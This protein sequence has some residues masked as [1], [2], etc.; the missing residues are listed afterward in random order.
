[1]KLCG[2][3]NYKEIVASIARY[4]YISAGD[5]VNYIMAD[6]GQPHIGDSQLYTRFWGKKIWFEVP[7]TF[8]EL[9][10]DWREKF[11][12]KG[13]KYG[14]WNYNE[15]KILTPE[16]YPNTESFEW[17]AQNAIWGT[18]GLNGDEQ[19]KYIMLGDCSEQHLIKIKELCEIRGKIDFI[20]K[21]EYWLAQKCK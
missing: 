17:Q 14:I 2:F 16:E 20:Q 15:V 13:R 7:Q 21:I 10:N 19:L 3:T 18:R 6:G 1:M 8:A 5:G 4:D 9:Y 11:H 12:G